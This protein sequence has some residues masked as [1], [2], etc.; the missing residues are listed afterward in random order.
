ML[1]P[2]SYIRHYYGKATDVVQDFTDANLTTHASSIAFFF[3]MALIPMMIIVA[4]IVSL[5]GFTEDELF[6]L[7]G[8]LVPDNLTDFV[9]TMVREA[10][11]NAGLAVTV[12]SAAL[13][14]TAAQGISALTRG[15]NA[16]YGV[17]ENRNAVQVVI[18]SLIAVLFLIVL[19]VAA[20]FL[21][22][23]GLAA[24]FITAFLPD[25]PLPSIST[26]IIRSLILLVSG[27][28][29]FAAGYTFLP[30]GSRKYREQL[31]GAMLAACAWF[32][33][34]FAFRIYVDHSTKFTLFYGSL[35]TVTIFLFWMYCI[36]SILLMGGFFNRCRSVWLEQRAAEKEAG[37]E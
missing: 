11:G 9:E 31:P 29:S 16:V 15:L 32:V 19:M 26:T 12:S 8:T 4:Y 33:F 34:S 20:M 14:W 35:G 3:F 21:V 22:F 17:E 10:Y 7:I 25:I 13:F 1:S 18:V 24:R 30:A 2:T 36:F 23:S 37:E 28:F 5:R 27:M 6:L